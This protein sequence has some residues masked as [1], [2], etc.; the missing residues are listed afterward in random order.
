MKT[1]S[2]FKN[3][4]AHRF[5]ITRQKD[6]Q[7]P[8]SLHTPAFPGFSLSTLCLFSLATQAVQSSDTG[9]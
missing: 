7:M 1:E 5:E 4:T 6:V 3:K 9:I 2:H 8:C